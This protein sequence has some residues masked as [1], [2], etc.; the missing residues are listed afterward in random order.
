MNY[1]EAKNKFI[2]AW[3][4]LATQWGINRT[5]AQI[6]ALLFITPGPLSVEEMMEE[7]QISRGNT[8]M[9]LRQLMDWGIVFKEIR[10]GDRKEYFYTEK[11][12]HELARIIMAERSRREIQPTIRILS[13]VSELKEDGTAETREFIKQTKAMFELTSTADSMIN[14][15]VKQNKNWL[16]NAVIKLFT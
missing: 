4:S 7:L 2:N 11:D 15:M 16:T 5:M 10:S 13:E 14:R 9:N 1:S 8:S 12:V 3:G 6:H